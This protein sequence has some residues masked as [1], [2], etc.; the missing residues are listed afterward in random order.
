MEAPTIR[1]LFVIYSH[2]LIGVHVSNACMFVHVFSKKSCATFDSI[3]N[4]RFIEADE[5]R[6]EIKARAE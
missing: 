5:R 2:R 1:E 6:T 3:A 4:S